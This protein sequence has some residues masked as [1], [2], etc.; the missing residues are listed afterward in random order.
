[1]T[2]DRALALRTAGAGGGMIFRD[3]DNRF[4]LRVMTVMDGRRCVAKA[5]FVNRDSGWLLKLHGA[6]WL[7]ERAGQGSLRWNLPRARHLLVVRRKPEAK[8]IMKALAQTG[9]K[10]AKV[11][12][13]TRG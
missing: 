12:K 4:G 13:Q 2:V 8:R 1:M 5:R 10:N 9:N 7:D 11:S 3:F 6:E